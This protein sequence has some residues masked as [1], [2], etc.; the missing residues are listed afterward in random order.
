MK[1]NNIFE[2]KE[3]NK[4]IYIK[5]INEGNEISDI[6]IEELNNFFKKI[7]DKYINGFNINFILGNEPS[8]ENGDPEEKAFAYEFAKSFKDEWDE[9]LENLNNIKEAIKKMANIQSDNKE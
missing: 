2:T 7:S 1:L 8:K 9:S 4:D 6:T 3:V 5:F